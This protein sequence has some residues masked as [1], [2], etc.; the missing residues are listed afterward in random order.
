L[1]AGVA[2]PQDSPYS[3]LKYPASAIIRPVEPEV[4]TLSNG[5]RVLL[6]ENHELGMVRGL[7]M[8][9][10]GSSLDPEGKD[11]L[12]EIAARAMRLGG[13]KSKTGVELQQLLGGLAA[14]IESST[15]A[16]STTWSFFALSET[17]D[18]VLQILRDLLIEPEFRPEGVDA[19]LLQARRKIAAETNSQL[20]QRGFVAAIEGRTGTSNIDRRD[21]QQFHRDH[22]ASNAIALALYGDFSSA[23]IKARIEAMF[24]KGKSAL[25]SRTP[26]ATKAPAGGIYLGERPGTGDASIV[27][28]GAS[29]ALTDRDYAA[30]QIATQILKVRIA[31]RLR[32]QVD[33]TWSAGYD[34]A[35][36]F[37]VTASVEP[38]LVT[39]S[40]EMLRAEMETLPTTGLS[41]NACVKL[42]PPKC[43]AFRK[44][45]CA[46][47]RAHCF[48]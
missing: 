1:G 15:D 37:S 7:A 44:I 20:V 11:G 8:L 9:R 17:L 41:W 39:Q 19:A 47:I 35:G 22:Y 27:I 4:L 42:S 45:T 25:V 10:A 24:P 30:V 18:P 12:A 26:G 32:R 43:L 6:V 21:I 5:M 48:V 14:T 40:I 29:S 16:S 38:E 28:G 3:D 36:T 23:A 46:S 13:T 34:R 31:A 33:A 2:L